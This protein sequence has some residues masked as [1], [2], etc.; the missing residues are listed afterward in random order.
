MCRPDAVD[1]HELHTPKA[2]CRTH[3]M[4]A[5]LRSP[6]PWSLA[7][8]S[9]STESWFW[10]TPKGRNTFRHIWT[11]QRHTA[12]NAWP[13]VKGH[14]LAKDDSGR[15]WPKLQGIWLQSALI[16]IHVNRQGHTDTCAQALAG[17]LAYLAH[18]HKVVMTQWQGL[19][20]ND[21]DKTNDQRQ[22]KPTKKTQL[23]I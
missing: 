10:P 6:S 20:A 2:G 22:L 12:N 17:L 8:E 13:W 9:V 14:V 5:L 3:F 19:A 23:G 18:A 7:P 1:R 11:A 21:A 16:A 4:E 15:E